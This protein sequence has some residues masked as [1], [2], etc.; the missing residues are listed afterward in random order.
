M[1]NLAKK[2]LSAPSRAFDAVARAFIETP[3]E[4]RLTDEMER[5]ARALAGAPL[6]RGG[7]AEAGPGGGAGQAVGRT[8]ALGQVCVLGLEL[9]HAD[10]IGLLGGQPVE[11]TFLVGGADAVEVGADDSLQ[12]ILHAMLS[13]ILRAPACVTVKN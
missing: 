3:D 13:P 8:H 7:L 2:E 10:N 4:T 9:L 5:L 11:K 1:A 12:E 6:P